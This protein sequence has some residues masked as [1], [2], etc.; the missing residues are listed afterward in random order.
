MNF[1]EMQEKASGVAAKPAERT[2]TPDVPSN[3]RPVYEVTRPG[4]KS[5]KQDFSEADSDVNPADLF[6]ELYKIFNSKIEE[7]AQYVGLAES[8]FDFLDEI[9]RYKLFGNLSYAMRRSSE[10]LSWCFV[11]QKMAYA[12][13]RQME[14]ISALDDFPQYIVDQSDLGNTI[15]ATDATRESFVKKS[16]RVINAHLR[17]GFCDAMTEQALTLKM[18]FSESSKTLRSM[19]YGQKDSN[20]LSS[21]NG[22]GT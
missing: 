18:E 22:T 5:L 1:K 11:Q 10:L 6:P 13:R 16:E 8:P 21:L 14:A 17:E 19:V 3:V 2:W 15:K 7:L 4:H 9:Q 20:N 12:R